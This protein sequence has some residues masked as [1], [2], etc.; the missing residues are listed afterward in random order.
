MLII[1]AAGICLVKIAYHRIFALDSGVVHLAHDV[2]RE[3]KAAVGSK[4]IDILIQQT[5]QLLVACRGEA[6]GALTVPAARDNQR[7]S[8]TLI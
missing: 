7:A 2:G 4:R 5:L 6:C 8:A 1:P 3:N